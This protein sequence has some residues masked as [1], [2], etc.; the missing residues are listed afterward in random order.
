MRVFKSAGKTELFEKTLASKPYCVRIDPAPSGCHVCFAITSHWL[1]SQAEESSNWHDFCTS[2]W[3]PDEFT[4]HGKLNKLRRVNII[5]QHLNPKTKGTG[6]RPILAL[7]KKL[8]FSES[9]HSPELC[10]VS[11]ELCRWDGTTSSPP[12]FPAE[13]T[14]PQSGCRDAGRQQVRMEGGGLPV[15]SF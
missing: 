3:S 4:G 1:K 11:H 5:L 8:P 10:R 15:T 12:R 6:A 14:E 13:E 7:K 9:F 2:R